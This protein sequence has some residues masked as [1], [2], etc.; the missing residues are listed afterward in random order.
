ME[1]QNSD[2]Q[3]LVSFS[4]TIVDGVYTYMDTWQMTQEEWDALTPDKIEKRQQEQY[5]KWRAFLD[6]PG[7]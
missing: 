1:I 7:A 5:K 3:A 6:S 4:W 2:P